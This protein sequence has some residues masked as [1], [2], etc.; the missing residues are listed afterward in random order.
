MERGQGKE[1]SFPKLYEILKASLLDSLQACCSSL[2]H[3]IIFQS[4]CAITSLNL[5]Y[6]GLQMSISN[7]LLLVTTN[8]NNMKDKN[9]SLK[10][11]W[12]QFSGLRSFKYYFCSLKLTYKEFKDNA[13]NGFRRNIFQIVILTICHHIQVQWCWPA[14]YL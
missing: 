8:Q 3:S 12:G 13:N 7:F 6:K 5:T 2:F 11:I 10:Q 14:F 9:G 1:P 4:N